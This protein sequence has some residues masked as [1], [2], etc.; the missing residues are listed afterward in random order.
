VGLR[1]W[2]FAGA[3]LILTALSTTSSCAQ[4]PLLDYQ[5][6]GEYLPKLALFA[7][8]PKSALPKDK[9][10]LVIGILGNDHFGPGLDAALAS[11][12]VGGRS[13]RIQR[14][15]SAA[16]VLDGTCHLLFIC[17]SEKEKVADILQALRGRPILTVADQNRFCLRGGMIN[18][19]NDS[20]KLRFEVNVDAAAASGITLSAKFLQVARITASR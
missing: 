13:L 18:F 12:H 16:D 9:A 7:D 11:Q 1:R 17:M 2:L 20:G 15:Q 6:K 3:W 5:A 14:F 10:P 19:I 8:W 4:E